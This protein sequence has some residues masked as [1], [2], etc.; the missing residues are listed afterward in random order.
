MTTVEPLVE[1]LGI[2]S[3]AGE[4]LIVEISEDD[5]IALYDKQGLQHRIV[6]RNKAG[7]STDV[8][9]NALVQISSFRP[10]SG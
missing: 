6:T 5:V 3:I 2:Y 10:I 1:L 4:D 8:E 7:F 9:E